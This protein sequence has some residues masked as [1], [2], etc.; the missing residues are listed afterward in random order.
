MSSGRIDTPVLS[1]TVTPAGYV[2]QYGAIGS[3]RLPHYARTDLTVS[4]LAQLPGARSAVLFASVGNLF[5]RA[6]FSLITL[7]PPPDYTQRRP[8]TSATPRVVYFGITLTR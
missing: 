6:D 8:V 3:E 4:Y 2:P 5:G 1:A 7:S